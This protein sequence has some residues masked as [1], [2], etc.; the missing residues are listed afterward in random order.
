MALKNIV[1]RIKEDITNGDDVSNFD[2]SAL[3]SEIERLRVSVK[4]YA[5]QSGVSP[6]EL[7]RCTMSEPMTIT[8]EHF[9]EAT[10]REPVDD[11]LE[12][13]NCPKA[14]QVMHWSCG[15]NKK[16]NRPVFEAGRE[17]DTEIIG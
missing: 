8:A 6:E 10:G 9:R 16:L 14:G 7:N 17:T 4:H 11:D 5:D 12:R 15:W 13:C 1:E 3:L 2:V